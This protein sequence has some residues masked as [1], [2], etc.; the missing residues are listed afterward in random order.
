MTHKDWINKMTSTDPIIKKNLY[1]D[2]LAWAVN[3]IFNETR[4]DREKIKMMQVYYGQ[5]INCFR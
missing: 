3:S 2:A 4:S 5:A 1:E